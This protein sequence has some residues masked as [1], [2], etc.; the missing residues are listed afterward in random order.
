MSLP[1]AL[2]VSLR[3]HQWTKNLVVLA[4]LAFSKHL[5]D[6]DAA[7]AGRAGVRRVLRASSGAV[8]LV[9]DL[10]DLERDRLHPV[11]RTRPIASGALP[12]A[13]GARRRRAA[14]RGLRPRRRPGAS[15]PGFFALRARVPRA[16]PRLLARPQ[17]RRHP[18]R[19]R[20]RARLRAARGGGRRRDR[21]RA[22][23]TGCSSARSCSRS[24]S[25]S[26]SAGTS[27]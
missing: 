5:F 2:L 20:D 24:S 25:P 16:Q 27:S 13:R 6:A 11:K 17:A 7:G 22:S 8:Y 19:A 10:V 9:N 26:P 12:V 23:A 15:G 14:A 1:R 18:R 4:A 3:P 21:G